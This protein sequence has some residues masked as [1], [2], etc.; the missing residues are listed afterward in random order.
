[1]AIIEHLFDPLYALYQARRVLADDGK[2]MLTTPNAV[3]LAKRIWTLIGRNPFDGFSLES[4]YNRHQHEFT[5]DELRDLLPTAGLYPT[6]IYT[7]PK[8]RRPGIPTII[9]KISELYESF[10]DQIIVEAKKGEP[11]ERLPDVYRQGLIESRE[12]HPLHDS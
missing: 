12:T 11:I 10:G 9:E 1:V 4:R 7:I 3:R 2:F 8:D 5:P 6:S